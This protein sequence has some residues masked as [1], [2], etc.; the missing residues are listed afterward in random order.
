MQKV[1]KGLKAEAKQIPVIQ[2]PNKTGS[3]FGT[4]HM[5]SFGINWDMN[6]AK[7]ISN[8]I[9]RKLILIAIQRACTITVG[10]AACFRRWRKMACIGQTKRDEININPQKNIMPINNCLFNEFF[11][12]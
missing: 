11:I 7:V 1:A 10:S 2:R 5:N 6:T 3:C 4:C 12:R 8:T 9:L